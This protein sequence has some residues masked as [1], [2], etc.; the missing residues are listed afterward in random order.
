MRPFADAVLG[1]R[2]ER[3]IVILFRAR[4]ITHVLIEIAAPAISRRLSRVDADRHAPVGDGAIVIAHALKHYGAVVLALDML[5]VEF[6]GAV[7]NR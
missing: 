1:G 3:G 7:I 4:D 2:R 5:R 6:D